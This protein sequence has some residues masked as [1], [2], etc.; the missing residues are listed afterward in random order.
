VVWGELGRGL[1]SL[2]NSVMHESKYKLSDQGD[3][4]DNAEELMSRTPLS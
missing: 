4:D 2:V 1:R 3:Y